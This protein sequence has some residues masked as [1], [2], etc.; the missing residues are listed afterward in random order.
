MMKDLIDRELVL[1]E[2]SDTRPSPKDRPQ[3]LQWLA[4]IKAILK[5]PLVQTERKGE[6][7][8]KHFPISIGSKVFVEVN[9]C[10]NCGYVV[11]G[12]NVSNFCPV[13]GIDMRGNDE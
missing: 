5:V 13:C 8:S 1:E 3:Y 9:I 10:S 7:I 12:N 11:E 2:L 6:W 4:D